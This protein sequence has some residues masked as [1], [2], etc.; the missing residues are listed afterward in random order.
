MIASRLTAENVYLT[1]FLPNVVVKV[2]VEVKWLSPVRLCN[3]MDCNPP[4][5]SVHGILQARVLGWVA[6]SFSTMD[7]RVGL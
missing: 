2:K 1:Y 6:I 5:S 3:S 7:V 4:G